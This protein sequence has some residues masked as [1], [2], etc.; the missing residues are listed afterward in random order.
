MCTFPVSRN[1]NPNTILFHSGSPSPFTPWLKT[2]AP[3]QFWSLP[4]SL[5]KCP[6]SGLYIHYGVQ[7]IIWSQHSGLLSPPPP[8][9]VE[10]DFMLVLR[11]SDCGT[12]SLGKLPR[13]GSG[14]EFGYYYA[15]VF[16]LR[17]TSQPSEFVSPLQ[18]HLWDVCGHARNQDDMHYLFVCHLSCSGSLKKHDKKAS[19]N[20]EQNGI[21]LFSLKGRCI[22]EHSSCIWSEPWL[23]KAHML[24]V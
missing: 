21:Y 12:A 5:R 6:R 24:L 7:E 10:I 1:P 17:E 11:Y 15:F 14:R 2:V 22:L 3:A 20:M 13:C 19:N 8:P 23:T 9:V 4:P 18:L 16:R